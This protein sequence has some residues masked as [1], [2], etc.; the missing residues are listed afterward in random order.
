M[1]LLLAVSG[2][3]DSMYMAN[4]ASDFYPEAS[5]DVAHCNFGLRGSESDG[6]E[7]FV[8]EWCASRGLRCH[9]HRFATREQAA[10]EGR[11]IEMTARDQRYAWFSELCRQEGLD[12]VVVAHNA[13]D[14][15]ET[16]LL[17]L[18]RGTGVKG[19]R[20]MAQES[21]RDDGLKILRPMLGISREEIRSWMTG[22]NLTWR[23]DSTNAE[24]V[25]KRNILRN[26]IFP[27]LEKI[28]PSFLPTLAAD[29]E[30]FSQVD[31]IAEDYF[32]ESGFADCT[33]NVSVDKLLA[34]D[35]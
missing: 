29:M 4:R 27:L 31:D 19:I 13:N 3:I 12:A 20:G 1:K 11:S 21:L 15:A 24:N 33:D 30:R 26:E 22:R 9:V 34:L 35:H 32:K 8:R 2:G 25:V 18:L 7:E 10:R 23:E 6:D 14:N 16:M 17:N 5:F 28:N